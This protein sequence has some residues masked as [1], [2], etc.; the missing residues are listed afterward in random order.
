MQHD[1]TEVILKRFEMMTGRGVPEITK[2]SSVSGTQLPRHTLC[3]ERGEPLPVM[4]SPA[5]Q[6]NNYV[7]TGCNWAVGELRPGT[8][9]DLPAL[10]SRG[11]TLPN[12]AF[13]APGGE[14]RAQVAG[15]VSGL[16]CLFW[17]TNTLI[18]WPSRGLFP[19]GQPRIQPGCCAA[20]TPSWVSAGHSG[21][22]EVYQGLSTSLSH[23]LGQTFN[24]EPDQLDKGQAVSCE[25]IFPPRACCPALSATRLLPRCPGFHR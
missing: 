25:L 1:G 14:L 13:R 9:S 7:S 11:N 4:K 24:T 10:S 18:P 22:F 8:C 5:V 3:A 15:S 16:C 19:T 23:V 12:G 2:F 21:D 17:G 20:G 6:L